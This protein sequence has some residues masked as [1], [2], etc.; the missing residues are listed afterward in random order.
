[1]AKILQYKPSQDYHHGK[2][3]PR[4]H[5]PGALFFIFFKNFMRIKFRA[6]QVKD[7]TQKL[8]EWVVIAQWICTHNNGKFQGF[9]TSK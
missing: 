9:K 4:P 7:M 1:M 3:Y 2:V 5:K 6:R 8:V